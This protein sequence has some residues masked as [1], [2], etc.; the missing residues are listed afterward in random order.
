MHT[1]LEFDRAESFNPCVQ[2]TTIPT[3]LLLS[4]PSR[5]DQAQGIVESMWIAVKMVFIALLKQL[6]THIIVNNLS[7][8]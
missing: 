6:P 2:E 3:P 4:Q 5:L 8:V 7:I 1:L